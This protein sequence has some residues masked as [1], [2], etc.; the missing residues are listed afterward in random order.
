MCIVVTVLTSVVA[1]QAHTQAVA[2]TLLPLFLCVVIPITTSCLLWLH[3]I[4]SGYYRRTYIDTHHCFTHPF[5]F[6]LGSI[7]SV[8]WMVFMGHGFT[9]GGQESGSMFSAAV[10]IIQAS[11]TVVLVPKRTGRKAVR[12]DRGKAG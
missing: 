4:T 7:S 3:L 2:W 10:C 11:K 6:I 1:T 9:S 8:V 5:H 12:V